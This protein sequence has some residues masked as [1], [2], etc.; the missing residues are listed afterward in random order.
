MPNNNRRYRLVLTTHMFDR[1]WKFKPVVGVRQYG[2]T[3]GSRILSGRLLLHPA[4][5][6]VRF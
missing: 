5:Q 4:G 2:L 6:F 3:V 1:W